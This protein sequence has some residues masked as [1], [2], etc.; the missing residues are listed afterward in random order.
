MKL[1]DLLVQNTQD[2][3]NEYIKRTEEFAI[4]YFNQMAERNRWN[5]KQWADFLGVGVRVANKGKLTEFITFEE[6]FYNTKKSRVYRSKRNE[7]SVVSK[8]GLQAQIDYELNKA[9]IHYQDS[10]KKLNDRLIKKGVPEG[11]E[12]VIISN[13]RVGVN[14]EITIQFNDIKVRAWTVVASGPVQ[15][16]HYRYLVK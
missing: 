7:C 14:L 8:R 3:Y 11:S 4:S 9:E 13:A 12:N 15:R 5:E 10:I 6:G 1:F 16:P 2:L